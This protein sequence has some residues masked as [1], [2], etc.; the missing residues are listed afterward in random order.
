MEQCQTRVQEKK[1]K[2]KNAENTMQETQY[3]NAIYI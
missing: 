3:L 2:K 1:N